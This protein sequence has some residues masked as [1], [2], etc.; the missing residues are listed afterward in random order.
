MPQIIRPAGYTGAIQR[1]NIDSSISGL[2][3]IYAW[4][5]AG[6]GGAGDG[7]GY[8]GNGSGGNFSSTVISVVPGDVLDVIVGGPGGMGVTAN[9]GAGGPSGAGLF[10]EL[11][12]SAKYAGPNQTGNQAPLT[13]NYVNGAYCEFLNSHGI[14][15]ASVAEGTFESRTW[16]V[17]FPATAWYT[18]MIS[19]DNDGYMLF[20]SAGIPFLSSTGYE[21]VAFRRA[22]ITAGY[23]TITIYGYNYGGPGSIAAAVLFGEWF[24]HN[25]SYTFPGSSFAGG[26][27]GRAG[28]R[29]SSGGGGGGGGCTVIKKNGVIVATAGGGGG[30][31]GAGRFSF[32]PECDAPGQLVSL[33]STQGG[34]PPPAPGDRGGGAGGG[35]GY[36]ALSGFYAGQYGSYRDHEQTGF[37]GSYGYS[38]G[39]VVG[40]TNGR[41][42]AQ[43]SSVYYDASRALG[44]AGYR[45][46]VQ[47]QSPG[48]SGYVVLEFDQSGTSVRADGLWK[49]VQAA[50]IRNNNAW[51]QVNSTWVKNN[52][53]WNLVQG[54]NDT[55]PPFLNIFT[56]TGSVIGTNYFVDPFIPPD[57]MG[58][59]GG[60]G[61]I[62]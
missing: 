58:G 39:D 6:G 8:A 51:A 49:E 9:I 3:N 36:S 27:G 56:Q 41:S 52:G 11:L 28:P 42:A 45:P 20:D 46:G 13:T 57:P 15:D 12:W 19:C 1:L 32:I 17:Y 61:D 5:G 7:G 62:F 60:M 35:G 24:T 53:T 16:T 59:I 29:G 2:C 40:Y 43:S 55:S 21:Q 47:S 4:G 18:F 50:W 26:L 44:G 14:W 54:T 30:G 22:L 23:H 38:L 10:P 34:T 31:G 37:G 48:T 33:A 25:T